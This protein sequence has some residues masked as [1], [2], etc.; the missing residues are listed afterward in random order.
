MGALL[1]GG[2][3]TALAAVIGAGINYHS[4]V[5]TNVTNQEINQTNLDY[6]AAQ[7]QAAW[8][9][10]DTAH[11]RE[12]ADLQAAGLSPLAST[13]G[14][15][16]STPLGSPS[17]LAMQAPQLDANAL[18]QGFANMANIEETKRHN[19]VTE[20]NRSSELQIEAERVVN[21]ANK[22]ELENKKVE[23]EIKYYAKLN[24]LEAKKI[25]ETIRNHKKSEQLQLSEHEARMMEHES[26]MFLEEITR[27]TG[28]KEIPYYEIHDFEI[29]VQS[30]K[31]YNLKLQHFIES[32]GATQSA[33]ASSYGY[34]QADSFG[35]GA[36]AK[37]A[38]TGVNGNFDWS[39]TT[40][41]N[42]SNYNM[43]NLS[44]KQ[45]AM[46]YKFLQENKCPVYIDKSK[47]KYRYGD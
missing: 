47:Y 25:D 14:L 28:G 46:W 15:S 29:Y 13:N 10:D 30:K 35:I 8:E 20:Q 19:L 36:G 40:G 5:K 7:T 23:S 16:V 3:L 9:R 42:T 39:E 6:N 34:T 44:E 41:E 17:P 24:E 22:L 33:S 31:L 4:Q 32:I 21:E 18:V 37:V 26:K 11:Q 2:L 45:K 43:E 1:A 12:V 38:G 27:Q